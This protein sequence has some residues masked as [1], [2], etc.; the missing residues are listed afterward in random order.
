MNTAG[1]SISSASPAMGS[2]ACNGNSYM[3][4]PNLLNVIEETHQQ[5]WI[6]HCELWQHHSEP[7]EHSVLYQQ[8]YS[9]NGGLKQ[10]IFQCSLQEQEVA[11][12]EHRHCEG[13]PRQ[14]G[15][16]DHFVEVYCQ[17]WL[18]DQQI[19]QQWSCFS[20]SWRQHQLE[21]GP[22]GTRPDS[23]Q[24]GAH[25]GKSHALAP[26][27]TGTCCANLQGK[28]SLWPNYRSTHNNGSSSRQFSCSLARTKTW[29]R[30]QPCSKTI[31]NMHNTKLED[32]RQRARPA[33]LSTHPVLC[34]LTARLEEAGVWSRF[35]RN[36]ISTKSMRNWRRRPTGT[37]WAR[38]RRTSYDAMLWHTDLDSQSTPAYD[39]ISS[40]RPIW[41]G[42]VSTC[43]RTGGW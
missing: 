17:S 35:P 18:A 2:K 9:H 24:W 32:K 33:L 41:N 4:D 3:F 26:C 21:Q 20:E 39:I 42:S 11:R 38:A 22:A 14:W 28:D 30:Q 12:W 23:W 31:T 1:M 15:R 7:A 40:F 8:S 43:Q 10:T 25:R 13:L 36:S 6:Q 5:H 29:N 19:C 16:A 34:L 37:H 27:S